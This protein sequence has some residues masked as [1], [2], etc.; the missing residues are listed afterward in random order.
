MF[1]SGGRAQYW[2]SY[3]EVRHRDNKNHCLSTAL[4][5]VNRAVLY[6]YTKVYCATTTTAQ[7]VTAYYKVFILINRP[8]KHS[9]YKPRVVGSSKPS[10]VLN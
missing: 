2:N 4:T 5:A 6:Y 8:T 10:D 3:E 7:R 9:Y 1:G